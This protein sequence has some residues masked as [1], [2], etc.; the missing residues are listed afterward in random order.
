VS[1]V[2]ARQ[3]HAVQVVLPTAGG[4]GWA[5]TIGL[6][7]FGL[8]ELIVVGGLSIPDQHDLLNDV[9]MRMRKGEVMEP[10]TCD[11]TI[12]VGYRA[13]FIE[14]ADTTTEEFAIGNKLQSDFRALQIVWPDHDDRFPWE[15]GYSLAPETQR[16]LGRP[17][18]H[19]PA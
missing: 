5:Y 17:P 3:G 4:P 7:T 16:L 6:H 19:E 13:A 1:N 8:P 12:L 15:P 18:A 14:V 9:A 10:G 2:I 11:D